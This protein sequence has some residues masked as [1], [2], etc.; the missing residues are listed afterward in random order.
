MVEADLMSYLPQTDGS[1]RF[2]GKEIDSSIKNQEIPGLS[3]AF[4]LLW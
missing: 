3:G 2:I 1:G 4:W